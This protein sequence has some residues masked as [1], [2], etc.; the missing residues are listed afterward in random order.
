MLV[1]VLLST[2]CFVGPA[3][4]S[5]RPVY[6]VISYGSVAAE[7]LRFACDAIEELF[8]I[9]CRVLRQRPLPPRTLD[10]ARHQYNADQ[11]VKGL[12]DEL[13]SDA[14]GL[15]AITNAD[16]FEPNRSRFVFGLASLVD[17]VGVVSLARYRGTWWGKST[18]RTEFYERFYKVLIHEVGHTLGVGHCAN[19]RCAM[20]DDR[21]L[22]DLDTSPQ[23]F[24]AVCR[25]GIKVGRERVPGTAMWH[26]MRGHSHLDRGQFA[27]AVLHFERAVEASPANAQMLNDLGVALL[28]RGDRAR[29]LWHFREASALEPGFINALYNEGLVFVSAGD[30]GMARLAFEQV[31]ATD[32]EWG[33]A[34][35]QLGVLFQEA[36]NDQDRAL[37]HFEAYL[38]THVDPAIEGRIKMIKGG[39]EASKP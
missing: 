32:A 16:L 17:H 8:E 2:L 29:A 15:M 30:A 27:R 1:G 7:H 9:R 13:P 14:V 4:A 12:F 36:F 38:A 23:R 21:S 39:G 34:H 20:R 33:L 26:Y 10:K 31:V 5:S 22:K 11:L 3:S 18:D 19:R 35:R 24:C 28:R 25:Q 37:E 6:Y